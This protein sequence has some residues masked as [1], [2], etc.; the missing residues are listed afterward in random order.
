MKREF[1]LDKPLP[2]QY[3]IWLVG[4]DWMRVDEDGDGVPD[5]YGTRRGILRG[6]FG[7]SFRNREPVIDEIS[8]RLPNTI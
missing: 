2:V 3:V 6:D 4:N 8:K 7:F 5:G 1:G